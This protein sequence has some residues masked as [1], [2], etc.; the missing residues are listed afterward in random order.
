MTRLIITIIIW[1]II[2]QI[3]GAIVK[4][5]AKKQKEDL[6]PA[7]VNPLEIDILDEIETEETKMED[8]PR[9]IMATQ[10]K[11][12][13]SPNVSGDYKAKVSSS[14]TPKLYSNEKAGFQETQ[15]IQK[16]TTP[17][18]SFTPKNIIQGVIISEILKKPKY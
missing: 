10:N 13:T 17:Y 6:Q 4:R 9:L 14:E 11:P 16:K 7:N 1:I 5:K 12:K 18:I 8:R 15:K 2:S 3:I